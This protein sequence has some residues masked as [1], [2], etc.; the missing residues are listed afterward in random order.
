[1]NVGN[2]VAVNYGSMWQ[3]SRTPTGQRRSQTEEKGLGEVSLR[4]RDKLSSVEG[5]G[6]VDCG[7][8]W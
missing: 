1:M 2:T 8:E 5:K 6:A 3:Q 4:V 7:E